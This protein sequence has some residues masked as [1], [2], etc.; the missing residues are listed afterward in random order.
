MDTLQHD[1]GI[2]DLQVTRT[3]TEYVQIIQQQYQQDAAL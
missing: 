1:V 3:S 2:T